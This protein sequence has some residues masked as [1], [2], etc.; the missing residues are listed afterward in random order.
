MQWS[1][2]PCCTG[3][4][5]YTHFLASMQSGLSQPM[6]VEALHGNNRSQK[7]IRFWGVSTQPRL[8]DCPHHLLPAAF[9][10]QRP[11]ARLHGRERHILAKLSATKEL[12]EISP[13][14]KWPREPL[15]ARQRCLTQP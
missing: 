2:L 8:Q 5:C 9:I 14:Q 1:G 11:A 4:F 13:S 6:R 15:R 7:S 12:R 3:F 10:V